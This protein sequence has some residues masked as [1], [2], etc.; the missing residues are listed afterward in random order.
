MRITDSPSSTVETNTTLQSSYT[1]ANVFFL[2]KAWSNLD[3][4]V[5]CILSHCT[6]LLARFISATGTL[7]LLTRAFYL[8]SSWQE[9][10]FLRHLAL[11][12]KTSQQGLPW[13][14]PS[15]GV[16]AHTCAHILYLTGKQENSQLPW[17][18]LAWKSED[19]WRA[20]CWE[21]MWYKNHAN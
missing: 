8:E 12:L 14:P 7:L 18:R 20:H 9:H 17:D 1:S 3:P 4:T 19:W 2:K 11:N 16:H 21:Q 13:S 5:S 6:I 15:K 10:V